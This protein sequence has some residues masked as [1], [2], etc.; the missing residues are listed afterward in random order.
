MVREAVSLKT[1]SARLSNLLYINIVSWLTSC[2]TKC[3]THK[4]FHLEMVDINKSHE[5]GSCSRFPDY[6]FVYSVKN[7][8]AILI[9]MRH[10][11]RHERNCHSEPNS[12]VPKKEGNQPE[13]AQSFLWK[14][15]KFASLGIGGKEESNR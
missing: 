8:G 15:L 6:H 14:A 11:N 10:R 2:G 7:C 4:H 13:N 12:V 3:S 9:D 5:Q 1:F